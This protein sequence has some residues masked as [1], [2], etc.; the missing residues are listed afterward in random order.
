MI[1]S[2]QEPSP[3]SHADAQSQKQTRRHPLIGFMKGTIT[4]AA[5][6]DLTEPA[7]PEWADLIEEKYGKGRLCDE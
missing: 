1:E 2:K 4:V 6:V 5:G 3:A 7:F